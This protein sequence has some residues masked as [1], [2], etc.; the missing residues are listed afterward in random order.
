VVRLE[1][2]AGATPAGWPELI[3]AYLRKYPLN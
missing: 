2:A 1:H 3:Q